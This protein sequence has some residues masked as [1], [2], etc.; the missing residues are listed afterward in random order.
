MA[1]ETG[2]DNLTRSFT[3]SGSWQFKLGVSS[4]VQQAGGDTLQ[5]QADETVPSVTC[6]S[7]FLIESGDYVFHARYRYLEP[8]R[9]KGARATG[10]IRISENPTV[11]LPMNSDHSEISLPFS[12]KPRPR[13]RLFRAEPCTLIFEFFDFTGM[14]EI[15]IESMQIL[16]RSNEE[17]VSVRMSARPTN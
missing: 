1:V 3:N 7:R 13:P 12:I 15:D 11:P 14:M 17:T 8:K 5:F 4:S 2:S 9:S 10:Q 6:N 16:Q